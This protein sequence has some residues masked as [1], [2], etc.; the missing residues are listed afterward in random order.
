LREC[1]ASGRLRFDPTKLPYLVN[2]ARADA[3]AARLRRSLAV[4]ESI[5]L[6]FDL[7]TELVNAGRFAEALAAIEALAVDAQKLNAEGWRRSGPLLLTLKAVAH[8]RMGE[9]QNCH[10]GNN[11]ESCLLPIQ[12]AGI[13]R[14][15]EGSTRAKEALEEALRL[16]PGYLRARWLLN[17]AHMTLGTYPDGVPEAQLIPPAVFMPEHPLPRF[18]N[19]AAAAGLDIYALSGGAILDDFDG[20]DHLDL[21]VSSIGFQDPL[22]FFHNRG[23][24]T[25]EERTAAAGLEGE[26][27]GLNLIQADYDNDGRKDALVL[28][29]G[30]MGSEGRFPLSLLHNDGGGRFSDATVAA[31]IT[32]AAP[33][34]TAVFFDYDGDGFLDLF[35][36]NESTPDAAHPCE[37]YRNNGN[38]TFTEVAA[39][40]GVDVLGFVKG[41][42]SADYD[43]DG[44]PDLYLSLGGQENLLFHNDGPGEG[45]RGWRFTN[46][47]KRAGVTEPMASFPRGVLRLRQ[48]RLHRPLRGRIRSHGRG[49]RRRLPRPAHERRARAALPEPR[50]RDLRRRDAGGRALPG[51][52]GDGYERG[53]LDNDGFLDLYVGT[54]NPDLGTLVPNRMFRNNEGRRFE[55][56][57]TAGGFGHLQKGHAICFGDVDEDGD[58]DIFAEMGG[59]VA[60]DKAYSALYRN[61]GNANGFVSIE[62]RGIRSNRDGIGARLKLVLE[63]AKGP[64]AIYRTLGSGG[65]FGASP[66]RFDVGTGASK[67]ILSAEVFWPVTGVTEPITGLKVGRRYQVIEGRPSALEIERPFSPESKR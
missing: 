28:R 8:L 67:R 5:A 17:I 41:V 52:D 25:F 43:N 34:Q 37:L 57:T 45:G 32:H 56:V 31:G 36:G 18:P 23:D 64:R 65:S 26:T 60:T 62:L 3:L 55:D 63:G 42:A 24:G 59:A 38:G 19:V 29:G 21:M 47:A 61:P 35:V 39:A 33:T 1:C 15:K 22:R 14:Q 10:A 9:E 54:G 7:C 13:H 20:D 49:R 51:V 58:Q 16:N 50:G 11:P 12:G 46:V 30:W 6:R 53:D 40:V 44:R 2:G 27:G 66:L 48:R 4:N